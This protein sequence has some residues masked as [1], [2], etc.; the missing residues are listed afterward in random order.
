MCVC[1]CVRVR[2]PHVVALV[3]A[4]VTDSSGQN[5]NVSKFFCVGEKTQNQ[6]KTNIQSFFAKEFEKTRLKVSKKFLKNFVSIM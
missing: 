3:A 2:E 6:E 1:V 4:A 5:P